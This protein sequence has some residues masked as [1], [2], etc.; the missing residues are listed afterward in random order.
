LSFP[1]F[2]IACLGKAVDENK[3][4]HAFPKGNK[5]LMLFADVDVLTYIERELGGQPGI[6]PYIVRAANR[7]TAREIHQEIRA[8]QVEDASRTVVGGARALQLLPAW[9]FGPYFWISTRIGR[10]YPR[11]W[12]QNWGTVTLSVG[13]FGN[14]AGWGIPPLTPSLCWVT[15]GGIAQKRQDREGQIG[16]REY[17]S[18]TVSAD[19]NMIDGGPAAR[20]TERLKELIES[21]YGLVDEEVPDYSSFS[22][23][24]RG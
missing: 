4:V 18:L 7:K 8:A 23:A 14:G 12:K 24:R 2:I 10:R 11:L 1:A 15:V 16:V 9:L 17:L 22:L 3:A 20:F 13:M 21:A 5:H 6:L 19:Y